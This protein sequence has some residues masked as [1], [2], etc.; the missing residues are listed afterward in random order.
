LNLKKKLEYFHVVSVDKVQST[1][2]IN[3]S[4]T[5]ACLLCLKL[6]SSCLI[7]SPHCRVWDLCTLFIVSD[8]YSETQTVA[9]DDEFALIP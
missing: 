9:R 4:P 6:C 8:I 5:L 1:H 2:F 7:S 3:R